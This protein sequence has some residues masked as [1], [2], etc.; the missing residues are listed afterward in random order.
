MSNANQAYITISHRP[1][2]YCQISHTDGVQEPGNFREN[3]GDETGKPLMV[4][5][6]IERLSQ[7][8]KHST[9]AI[10]WDIGRA[11]KPR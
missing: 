1:T 8:I 10:Y 9:A 3:Y 2:R 11:T 4:T 7:A 5:K 6:H